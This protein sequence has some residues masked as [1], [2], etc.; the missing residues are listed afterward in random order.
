MPRAFSLSLLLII[1]TPA[2]TAQSTNILHLI[3]DDLRSDALG[4]Y[5]PTAP[6]VTPYLDALAADADAFVFSRAYVQE[7]VCSPSRNSFLSGLRPDSTRAWNF[8]SSFRDS[9]PERVPLPQALKLAG[10]RTLGMGKVY[11]PGQ[12]A[13]SDWPASW[14]A[15]YYNCSSPSASTCNSSWTVYGG[16]SDVQWCA[17]DWPDDAFCDG[18]LARRAVELLDGFAA[19]AEGSAPPWCLPPPRRAPPTTS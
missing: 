17:S 14:T 6:R 5:S 10:W 8:K 4:V 7:A 13:L 16:A 9:H 1:M 2:S 3:V 18:D 11:H 19:E 12:P 15:D